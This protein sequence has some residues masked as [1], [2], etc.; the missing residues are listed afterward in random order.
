VIFGTGHRDGFRPGGQ[1]WRGAFMRRPGRGGR[2]PHGSQAGTGTGTPVPRQPRRGI[3]SAQ[4]GTLSGFRELR[5]RRLKR[6]GLRRDD[7]PLRDGGATCGACRSR[8]A[9]SPWRPAKPS[10]QGPPPYR[11]RRQRAGPILCCPSREQTGTLCRRRRPR[12]SPAASCQV[13]SGITHHARST[14]FRTGAHP[15][16]LARRKIPNATPCRTNGTPTPSP[17]SGHRPLRDAAAANPALDG[18]SCLRAP[19]LR[20]RSMPRL[21]SAPGRICRPPLCSTSRASAAAT[22]RTSTPAWPH[23]MSKAGEWMLV[24][25]AGTAA[26]GVGCDRPEPGA[27]CS[28]RADRGGARQKLRGAQREG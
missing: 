7:D 21:A 17:R 26:A 2:P 6:S 8:F 3:G 9:C 5:C 1:A 12:R 19:R 20:Q 23:P 13:P 25:K 10:R 11:R 16:C 15:G 14:P 22:R 18:L 4:P 27:L 24:W 28:K